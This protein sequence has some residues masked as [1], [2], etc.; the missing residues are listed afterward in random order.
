MCWF[1]PSGLASS[2]PCP[3]AS[4]LCCARRWLTASVPLPPRDSRPDLLAP[5]QSQALRKKAAESVAK[6]T[7]PLNATLAKLGY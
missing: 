2:C 3:C 4:T 6:Q 1:H 5:Q 7:A